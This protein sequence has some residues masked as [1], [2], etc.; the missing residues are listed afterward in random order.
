MKTL[1]INKFILVLLFSFLLLTAVIST[2]FG[3][4][5]IGI[6][7]VPGI[8]VNHFLF[9]DKI[10]DVDTRIILEL[11]FPRIILSGV[12]GAV[13][14]ISGLVYQTILKNPLTEPF[15]LG[16]SSGSSFGAALGIFILNV[17]SLY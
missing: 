6:K 1:S 5:K 10:D 9:K 12:I 7:N 15:T 3:S 13:L 11:R 2:G 8:I 4:K 14:A 16:I 17:F